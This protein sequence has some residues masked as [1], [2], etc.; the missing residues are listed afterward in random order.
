MTIFQKLKFLFSRSQKRQLIIIGVLILIGMV[1]EMAGLGI[2]VPALAILLKTDIGKEYPSIKPF[3]NL[4]GNPSQQKLVII[5]MSFLVLLYLIKALF[6]LY[7]SSKQARFSA[8]L[9]SGLSRKLFLGYLKQPYSFHL[10]RNSAQ[11]LRNIQNEVSLFNSITQ[12]VIVIST[13]FSMILSV[14][15]I[16]II[17]EPI[18]AISITTFFGFSAII[19]H[20]LTKKKLLVWGNQRQFHLGQINQHLLQG[21]GAVK[22]VKILGREKYFLEE[23]DQ[24]NTA[25]AKIFAKVDTLAVVPRLYLELLTMIGMAGLVILM[26]IQSK[27]LDLLLPTLGVFMAAAFRMIPSVNRIMGSVQIIRYSQPVIE[28]LYSEFSIIKKYEDSIKVNNESS[29]SF[30]N[31]LVVENLNFQYPSGIINA[32]SEISIQIRRGESIGFIGPSGSGKSTLIDIILGLL[33]PNTGEIKVDEKSIHLNLREWQNKIGYV[34]QTIYLTDD[35][36]RR[37]VAFGLPDELINNENVNRAIKAAQL[38]EFVAGQPDGLDTKVGERGIRLS[39]GQRQRIGI[40]RALYH[41]PSVLVLDEATS[42][43]DTDTEKGVMSAVNALHGK[44]TILIVAHRLSTVENC[45][46]LYKLEKGRIVKVDTPECEILK[47]LNI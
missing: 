25:Q 47:I 34:P 6:M 29:T 45:D 12:S 15:L 28:N 1:L 43:L 27:P 14:A 37:N 38:E 18:G 32:L 10:Q 11:L 40:A 31:F 30:D 26:I 46:R 44:K 21:L 39:G 23:F 13:E 19:F 41:D 9:S 4:I 36:L 17:L 3:L 20:R 16:L 35:T 22:D 2:M 7:L 42:A 24:H 8:G 33:T 5:G